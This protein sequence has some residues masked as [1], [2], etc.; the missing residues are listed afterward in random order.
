M[1]SIGF[2]VAL[3]VVDG[4]LLVGRFFEFESVVEF[5]REIGVRRKRV[6][7]G[8]FSLGVKFEKLIGHVADGFFDARLARF[9]D[10][11]AQ[12]VELGFDAAERRV[13]LNEI[14]ARERDVEFGV[15]G[16]FAAA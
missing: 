9:P 8:E 7:D 16:K 12:A 11:G 4:A 15:A 1:G 13:F 5:A 14:D 6:A 3:H 2:H 10:G